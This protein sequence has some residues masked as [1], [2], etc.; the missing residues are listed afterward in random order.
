MI[1]LKL[2]QFIPVIHMKV[3]VFNERSVFTGD[4]L[5]I[6]GTGRTDFQ[7]AAL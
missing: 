2:K 3:S 7:N 6:G 4:T 1:S 5:L